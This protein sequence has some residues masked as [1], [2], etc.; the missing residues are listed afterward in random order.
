MSTKDKI[1][2]LGVAGLISAIAITFVWAMAWTTYIIFH[3]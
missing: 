3:Q 1:I 2:T